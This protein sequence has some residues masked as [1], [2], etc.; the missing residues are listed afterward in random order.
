MMN[1]VV[2]IHEL[3]KSFRDGDVQIGVLQ[4]LSFAVAAGESLAITGPSGSGKS[5][6]LNLLAGT[7][8]PDN[9]EMYFR[10]DGQPLAWHKAGERV[11]TRV[12]RR[13][14]GYVHQ[15]FNLIPTLTVLEN[16]RLPAHLNKLP[17]LE[18]EALRLLQRFGLEHRLHVFPETLSGGEQ[19]RVAVAR[20]LLLKPV[21]LLAD[22]PTGNLDQD[23]SDQVAQLLFESARAS[24]AALI[25]ATHSTQVAARAQQQL[26]L[27]IS[28]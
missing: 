12:R 16:V 6:L 10:I 11:R 18:G 7:V 1:N 27:G 22:E 19:Q 28:G 2:T 13:W 24:G 9:G 21:L 17:Q 26:Q 14:I 3:S 8:T 25:V 20:A 23:N 15:F 5:T 4:G